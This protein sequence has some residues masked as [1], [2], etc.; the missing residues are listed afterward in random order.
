MIEIARTDQD[1]YFRLPAELQRQ[2]EGGCSCASCKVHGV[3]EATW[4]TLVRPIK[5]GDH[6]YTGHMPDESIAAFKG[7]R[8]TNPIFPPAHAFAAMGV[9]TDNGN[10]Q[11]GGEADRATLMLNTAS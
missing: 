8:Q 1:I 7:K 2:I 6:S 9:W 11:G 5:A 4:D 3:Y 10:D